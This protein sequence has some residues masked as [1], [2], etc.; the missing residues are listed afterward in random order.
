[1][2][3]TPTRPRDVYTQETEI[4]LAQRWHDDSTPQAA[5][6]AWALVSAAIDTVEDIRD[7]WAALDAKE[8]GASAERQREHREA[9]AEGKTLRAWKPIDYRVQKADRLMALTAA[10]EQARKAHRRYEAL[11]NDKELLREWRVTLL[12]N[13]EGSQ[14][15]ARESLSAARAAF[16][17]WR[18][19]KAAL[20]RVGLDLGLL[21]PEALSVDTAAWRKLADNA[22]DAWGHIATVVGTGDVQWSGR[23]AAMDEA[24]YAMK[25]QLW[26]RQVMAASA[27]HTREFARLA[28]IEADERYAVTAFTRGVEQG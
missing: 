8:R 2:P 7:E 5:H 21:H 22:D 9:S 11:R 4:R 27:G 18:G 23:Y 20:A 6:D 15:R 10:V 19:S 1:M 13:F 17:Q 3:G 26:E 24:S 16:D 14:E 12:A 28:R 25:P